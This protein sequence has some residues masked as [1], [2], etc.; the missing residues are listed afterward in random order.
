MEAEDLVVDRKELQE[1]ADSLTYLVDVIMQGTLYCG[2]G[3]AALYF[4]AGW[5]A[6]KGELRRDE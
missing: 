6:A 5:V 2:K 4:T 3:T 1:I